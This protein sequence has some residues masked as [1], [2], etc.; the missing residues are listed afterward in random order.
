MRILEYRGTEPKVLDPEDRKEILK[1][2]AL[3]L[4]V[5]KQMS[6]SLMIVPEGTKLKGVQE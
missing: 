3:Q 2:M 1:I 5:L 6:M 4:E